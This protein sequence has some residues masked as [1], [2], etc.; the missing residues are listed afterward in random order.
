VFYKN[1]LNFP[2]DRGYQLLYHQ[3]LVSSSIGGAEELAI[4]IHKNAIRKRAGSSELLIPAGSASQ[5][6]A[7]LEELAYRTYR[8]DR[9]LRRERI[10]SLIANFE[11]YIKLV[12]YRG[13]LHIHSPFVFGAL[14]PLLWV[15]KLRTILHL[16]LDYSEDQLRWPMKRPPDLVIVC[17]KF[18]EERVQR[19][20]YD[21]QMKKTKVTVIANTVDAKRFNPGDRLQAKQ[22]FGISKD[23]PVLLMAANLAPHKGQETAIRATSLLVKQGYRPLLWIAGEERE[24][25]GFKSYLQE[26]VENLSLSQ[27]VEFLGYRNDVPK[28]LK[29]SD[30]LLLPSKHEG[31]PLVILEAQASKVLALAAPTAGIPEVIEDGRT[32]FLIDADN[33]NGYADVMISLLQNADFANFVMEAAYRQIKSGSSIEKYC[34]KIFEQYDGLMQD[35]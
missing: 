29:V 6:L 22:K 3:V 24:V 28:L 15:S 32:G 10:Q 26:L 8:L 14:R 13:L 4:E 2:S 7:E 21:N 35:R 12:G 30:F 19:F 16:H 9:L 25:G 23:R 11:L 18:M 5:K 1:R 31:L 34:E 33:P 27:F 20:I 17:A